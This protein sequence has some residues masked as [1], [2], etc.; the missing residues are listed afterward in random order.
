MVDHEKEEEEKKQHELKVQTQQAVQDKKAYV[1]YL[2]RNYAQDMHY[3]SVFYDDLC[4]SDAVGSL[5]KHVLE[6]VL[7]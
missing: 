1:E 4:Y 6:L 7:N 5:P 2:I 3:E